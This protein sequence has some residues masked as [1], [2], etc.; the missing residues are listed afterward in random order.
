MFGFEYDHEALA[1]AAALRLGTVAH[2]S[3]P[4]GIPFP[5]QQFDAVG[6]FDVLEHLEHPV[7]SLAALRA[8]LT[9]DG[10]LVLTVPAN[11]WLWGPHD[12]QHQHFRRYTART[13][14][15]HLR[16]AGMRVEYLSYLN[17]LLLPL[18]IAQRIKERIFG[19]SVRELSPSPVVNTTLFNIYRFEKMWI[20]N[21]RAPFGLSLM[22]I[23][24]PL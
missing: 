11:P 6:L 22:A 9:P 16:E 13:L 21:A 14:A 12:V 7:E 18:A 2:G 20:P 5:D 8:R 10:A 23:A 24:R 3:L 1:A 17:T 19:Y 15:E 4:D